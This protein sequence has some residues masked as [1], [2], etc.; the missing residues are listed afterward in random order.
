MHASSEDRE[1]RLI[2]RTD[3]LAVVG[4]W[5]P[6]ARDV[7][8]AVTGDDVS[9]TGFPYLTGR[10]I[11]VAGAPIWAQ[12]VTYVGELGWELF[13]PPTWAVQVWDALLAAGEVHG[14]APAGYRALDGL[15]IE[16]GY[17]YVG[18]DLTALDTPREAGLEMCVAFDGRAFVGRDALIRAREAPRLTRIRTLLLADEGQYVTAYGGEAV[19]NDDEVVGRLRSCAYG[20]SIG[21]TVAYAYLP[22]ELAPG[23]NVE[24]DVFGERVRAEVALDAVY[25]PERS[26]ILS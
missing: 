3:D 19:L 24:V 2:D 7:L 20:Y 11:D 18:T 13:V 16:K 5:G 12:R 17:R 4:L 14:I 6:R 25:D 1:V 9:N 10:T 8:S 15:R 22:E 26:R 21:R 23:A